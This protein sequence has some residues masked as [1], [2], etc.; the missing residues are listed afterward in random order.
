MT[1]MLGFEQGVYV[2]F[3]GVK[4]VDDVLVGLCLGVYVFFV[5]VKGVD[6]VLVGLC[7]GV[8]VFF[9]GV[10]GVDDVLAGRSGALRSRQGRLTC[11]LGVEQGVHE[12]FL[13]SRASVSSSVSSR[14][15]DVL[16]G[17]GAGCSRVLLGVKGVGDVLA[18][19]GA[20]S[21][22]FLHWCQRCR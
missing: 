7:L 2:F 4:G 3:V 19:R 11:L 17:R 22:R 14:A 5:G 18:R 16:A 12:F 9:V 1:C 6:D 10:K 20:G 8:Y 15:F 13:V 21:S